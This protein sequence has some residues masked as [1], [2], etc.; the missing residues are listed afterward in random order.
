MHVT[1]VVPT[2]P[3]LRAAVDVINDT[4]IPGP[5]NEA[6]ARWFSET[7][8]YRDSL[9]MTWEMTIEQALDLADACPAD[10]AGVAWANELR[11]CVELTRADTVRP[12]DRIGGANEGVRALDAF[13][14]SLRAASPL[15]APVA[16]TLAEQADVSGY[17]ADAVQRRAGVNT[18]GIWVE[19]PD[20]DD[21]S[22]L[23]IDPDT[24]TG[25]VAPDGFET[26]YFVPWTHVD[27]V[28]ATAPAKAVD[29]SA[30]VTGLLDAIWGQ[31]PQVAD[32]DRGRA[33]GMLPGD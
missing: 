30:E 26:H 22:Y 12:Y 16:N 7:S 6:F 27:A 17:I 2:G 19:D 3:A 13:V 21:E 18:V 8:V 10:P 28:R 32:D 9:S 11:R 5:A 25:P 24:A 29:T 4:Q 33:R 15:L 20:R 14:A 31:V 1:K 23:D